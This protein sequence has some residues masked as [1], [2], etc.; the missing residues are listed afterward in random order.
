MISLSLV[1]TF[2][3]SFTINGYYERMRLD[4]FPTGLTWSSLRAGVLI[5]SWDPRP[6]TLGCLESVS[7][8]FVCACAHLQQLWWD[9]HATQFIHRKCTIKCLLADLQI[10]RVNFRKFSSSQKK[11]SC[12]L[13]Y[14]HPFLLCLQ[15]VTIT[16]LSFSVDLPILHIL[17]K[18]NHGMCGLFAT[19]F[20]C[21]ACF[22]GPSVLGRYLFLFMVE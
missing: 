12:I 13:C 19:S 22:Q 14:Q 21:W 8:V 2:F 6:D 11:K 3:Y 17:Y 7:L 4:I 1:Q 20:F 10:T 16:N 9:L 18:W 5:S 15:L